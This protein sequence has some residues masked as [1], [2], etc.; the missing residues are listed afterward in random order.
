MSSYLYNG[1]HFT[2]DWTMSVHVIRVSV[3]KKRGRPGRVRRRGGRESKP[4]EVGIELI[5]GVFG[6]NKNGSHRLIYL[7]A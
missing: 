6:L 7:N 5:Q 1:E 3:E 4:V 2:S